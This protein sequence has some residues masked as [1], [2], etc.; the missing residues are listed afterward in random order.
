MDPVIIRDYKPED[1]P[2]IEKLWEITGLGGAQRGDNQWVIERSLALGG[3]LIIAEK[4][5]KTIV[6]SSWITYD[7]RRLHLHHL[8][9]LPTYQRRGIGRILTI[10]SIAFARE[11]NI[12]IKLEVHKSNK[13]AISLYTS[14]GFVSLGDYGVY[15]IRE[16]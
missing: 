8:G 5:N 4:K 6:G 15:I 12:Q 9:V 11:K 16:V 3:R 13:A 2:Q 7:G 14:L 1:Y 10:E